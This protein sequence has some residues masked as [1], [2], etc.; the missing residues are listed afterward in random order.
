MPGIEIKH[1]ETLH[2]DPKSVQENLKVNDCSNA[3]DSFAPQSHEECP[4]TEKS[5][6]ERL[7]D[8]GCLQYG[9]WFLVAYQPLMIVV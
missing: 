4:L 1:P 8:E 2:I 9:Y 6:A 5:N 3:V 7:L